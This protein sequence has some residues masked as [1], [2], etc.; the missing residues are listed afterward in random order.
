[1]GKGKLEY[2]NMQDCG[3]SRTGFVVGGYKAPKGS[4][5]FIV[6]FTQVYFCTCKNKT[7]VESVQLGNT[8]DLNL[9][10][11]SFLPRDRDKYGGLG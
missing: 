11:F 1:M 9:Q 4:F 3:V 2:L 10:V 7:Q 5:P 8:L 6:S